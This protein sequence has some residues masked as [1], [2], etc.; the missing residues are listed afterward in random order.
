MSE[1][2]KPD[3]VIHPKYVKSL[4]RFDL[5]SYFNI[6]YLEEVMHSFELI[7]P[8]LVTDYGVSRLEKVKLYQTFKDSLE[9]KSGIKPQYTSYSF[10]CEDQPIYSISFRAPRYVIWNETDDLTICA[11]CVDRVDKY[12]LFA[13]YERAKAWS[14][15]IT[16]SESVIVFDLDET[17]ISRE[18]KKLECAD[19]LLDCCRSVYDKIVLYSHGSNLHVDD[20][21]TQFKSNA[22][23]LVLSNNSSQD[24]PCNKNLLSLYNYFPNTIFTKATLVDDSLYNW[25]PEYSEL[26]VPFQLSSVEHIIPLIK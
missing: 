3:L 15:S 6:L 5:D 17:L 20:N 1:I 16:N 9:K 10:D 13:A 22:F 14:Y 2:C 11:T 8:F 26:I 23:D 24:K 18:C 12:S 4:L 7:D 25:T 21:V 19:Q